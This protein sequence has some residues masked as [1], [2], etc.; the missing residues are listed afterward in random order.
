MDSYRPPSV[1]RIR[2]IRWPNSYAQRVSSGLAIVKFSF[3][4]FGGSAQDN[5]WILVADQQFSRSDRTAI[6]RESGGLNTFTTARPATLPMTL[7]TNAFD[8]TAGEVQTSPVKVRRRHRRE[9][10]NANYWPLKCDENRIRIQ[11]VDACASHGYS[12]RHAQIRASSPKTMG[13]ARIRPQP[14][15]ALDRSGRSLRDPRRDAACAWRVRSQRRPGWGGVPVARAALC[16]AG[17]D[18]PH[19]DCDGGG[20]REPATRAAHHHIGGPGNVA[21]G[22]GRRPRR[23]IAHRAGGVGHHG[24]YG[25]RR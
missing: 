11:A 9:L 21:M 13:C 7:S 23:R 8:R 17:P 1:G 25:Q 15:T 14:A 12:S 3:R 19:G 16:R 24:P 10:T 20:D 5:Y 2:Q 4:P 6:S 18:A 22:R